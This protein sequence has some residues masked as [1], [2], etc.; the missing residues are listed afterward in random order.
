MGGRTVAIRGR[1]HTLGA[2]LR[3][4]N[5][6]QRLSIGMRLS[7]GRTVTTKLVALPAEILIYDLATNK[8]S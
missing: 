8:L 7:G 3:S 5:A 6:I 1:S 4:K 2:F